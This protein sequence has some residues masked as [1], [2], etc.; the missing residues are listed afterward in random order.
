MSSP[1]TLVNCGA[2]LCGSVRTSEIPTPARKP[3]VKSGSGR[4]HEFLTHCRDVNQQGLTM[5]QCLRHVFAYFN[6]MSQVPF[7]LASEGGGG[8]GD[9]I[10]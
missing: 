9:V 2:S 1:M 10:P 7:V 8:L 3:F 4:F 5:P 6:L